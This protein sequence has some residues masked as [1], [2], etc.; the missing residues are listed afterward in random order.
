MEIKVNTSI[1]ITV[2]ALSPYL[3]FCNKDNKN[4]EAW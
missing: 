2:P 4:I 3:D 1:S